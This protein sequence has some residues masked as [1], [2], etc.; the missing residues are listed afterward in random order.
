MLEINFPKSL[1]QMLIS[2]EALYMTAI[3]MYG[4]L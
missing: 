2:K 4:H 3:S 1:Y